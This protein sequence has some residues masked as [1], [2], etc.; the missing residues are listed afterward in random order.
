MC[1]SEEKVRIHLVNGEKISITNNQISEF[2]KL[3]KWLKDRDTNSYTISYTLLRGVKEH[4]LTI[5]S[6]FICAV[7]YAK[8]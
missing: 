3:K 7:D 5:Y 2:N 4:T 6:N 8:I 1:E